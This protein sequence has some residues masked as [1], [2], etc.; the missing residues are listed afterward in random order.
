VECMAYLLCLKINFPSH[1]KMLRGNHESRSMTEHFTFREEC[2]NKFDEEV[3]EAFMDL[4]DTLPLAVEVN[5]D[6]LC[7]HG[8][9]SP[10][11]DNVHDINKVNR[12]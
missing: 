8:G 11:L 3:Y 1:I 5:D 2:L 6:Y 4:F 7:V 9:I 12:F 10:N